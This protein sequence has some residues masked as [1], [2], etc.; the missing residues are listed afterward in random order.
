MPTRDDSP[1]PLLS[2]TPSDQTLPSLLPTHEGYI[3]DMQQQ[4]R[5]NLAGSHRPVPSTSRPPLPLAQ[6]S[7]QRPQTILKQQS[8]APDAN[9]NYQSAT[10]KR[11]N[12]VVEAVRSV[13][14][15]SIAAGLIEGVIPPDSPPLSKF[16]P[17]SNQ[18]AISES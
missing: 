14:L 4:N 11:V 17:T 13:F 16:N 3:I 5:H 1:I 15:S 18:R 6:P 8:A 7:N 9:H 2:A 12:F 10:K